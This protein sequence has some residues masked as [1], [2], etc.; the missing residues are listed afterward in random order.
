MKKLLL[1]ILTLIIISTSCV[2]AA[3]LYDY[4]LGHAAIGAGIWT[5]FLG[6]N[7]LGADFL[8]DGYYQHAT[9]SSSV[10]DAEATVGLSHNFA[11]HY[12][13]NNF[14]GTYTLAGTANQYNAEILMQELTLYY[15]LSSSLKDLATDVSS[16]FSSEKPARSSE[17]K[18]NNIVAIFAGASKVNG[19]ISL[20]VGTPVTRSSWGPVIGVE[21]AQELTPW[22]VSTGRLTLS[23]DAS[24]YGELGLSFIVLPG[25]SIDVELNTMDTIADSAFLVK[26]GVRM[27]LTWQY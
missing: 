24:Y 22:L 26:S 3:P 25:T 6:G 18:G 23:Q 13:Y 9:N 7:Q 11:I 20:P 15:R 10:W 2:S 17:A 27:G 19:S 16:V 5:N 4:R 8:H 1:L 12:G 21:T 14:D